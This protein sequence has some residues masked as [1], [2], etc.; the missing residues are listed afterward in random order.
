LSF[1]TDSRNPLRMKGNRSTY[2]DPRL[3]YQSHLGL[4]RA[5]ERFD[6]GQFG[7]EQ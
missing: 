3:H 2:L 4:L 5:C 1:A 7:G 6:V